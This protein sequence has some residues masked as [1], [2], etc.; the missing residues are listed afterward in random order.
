MDLKDDYVCLSRGAGNNLHRKK[1][2]EI[3][4]KKEDFDLEQFKVDF[5]KY[6]EKRL[7]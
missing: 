1:S 2:I 5:E 4:H 6:N 3:G 7:R